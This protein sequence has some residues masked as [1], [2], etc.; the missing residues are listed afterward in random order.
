MRSLIKASDFNS[1]RRNKFKPVK[2]NK[3][4]KVGGLRQNNKMR[5][6]SKFLSQASSLNKLN[7]E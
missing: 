3:N 1:K 6:A 5:K 7:A 2:L 4:E